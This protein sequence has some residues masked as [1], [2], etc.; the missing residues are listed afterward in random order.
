MCLGFG[1]TD[2]TLKGI[3]IRWDYLVNQYD[4]G[5]YVS[6]VDGRDNRHTQFVMEFASVVSVLQV[7]WATSSNQL[8]RVYVWVLG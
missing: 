4:A 5:R 3:N 7:R 2:F 8:T 6:S 1:M